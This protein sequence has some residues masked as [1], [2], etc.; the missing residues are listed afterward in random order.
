MSYTVERVCCC[1][2]VNAGIMLIGMG[3]LNAALF[4]FAEFSTLVPYYW[5]ID[6][7]FAL[8]YTVRT[9]FFFVMLADDN[10]KTRVRYYDVHW[11]TLWPWTVGALAAIILPWIEWGHIPLWPVIGYVM[12]AGCTTYYTLILKYWAEQAAEGN[13]LLK[14]G[15]GLLGRVVANVNDPTVVVLQKDD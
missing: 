5:S 14:N 1:F 12:L 2:S 4:Y 8:L 3:Q 15:E 6:L 11:Y 7:L 9:A 13:M 10:A